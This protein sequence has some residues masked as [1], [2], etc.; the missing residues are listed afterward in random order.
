M[1]LMPAFA[2]DAKSQWQELDAELQ[3]L[4]LDEL[5][6]IAIHP[7]FDQRG[8]VR[9]DTVHQSDKARHY[10][11]LRFIVDPGHVTL[12]GIYHH[13]SPLPADDA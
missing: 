10:L 3:E 13:I 6:A 11:F 7:P 12:V 1:S 2:P 8:E 4:V 5:D 9:R